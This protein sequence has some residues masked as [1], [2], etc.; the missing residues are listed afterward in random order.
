MK[1]HSMTWVRW[2][3]SV[4]QVALDSES[5]VTSVCL[6][7]PNHVGKSFVNGEY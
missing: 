1:C 7:N 4:Y 5:Y 2:S 6:F 3:I